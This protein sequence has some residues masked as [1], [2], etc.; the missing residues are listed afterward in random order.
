MPRR[1]YRQRRTTEPALNCCTCR[2]SR[3]VESLRNDWH[4]TQ[5]EGLM[6]VNGWVTWAVAMLALLGVV[7]AAH[8]TPLPAP[9]SGVSITNL[10][11]FTGTV[12]TSF[13]DA[14]F[15]I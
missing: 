5:R 11:N 7:T 6:K 4:P 1:Q 3:A 14:S 13:V 2:K 10:A 15:K 8:A 9:S 12:V